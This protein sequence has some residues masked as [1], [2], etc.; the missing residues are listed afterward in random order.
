MMIVM[1]EGASDGQIQSIV[2]R[3]TA[4]GA[5]AHVSRGEFVTVIGAIGDDRE[6]VASL[7]LEGEEGVERV[8]PILKPYK[9]AS[10]D[11]KAENTEFDMGNGV[12]VGGKKIVVVMDH[13]D[14]SGGAK[15]LKA[16]T[17]PLTGARVV[18]MVV[19]DIAVFEIQRKGAVIVRLLEM[20]P[21]VTVDEVRARTEAAEGAC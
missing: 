10:R 8:V 7:A 14:K 3:V 1:K 17:L 19:T 11:Y 4:A 16:C 18:D 15:F 21:G 2:D 9:L 13:N 20:A 6:L 5:Q 12:K